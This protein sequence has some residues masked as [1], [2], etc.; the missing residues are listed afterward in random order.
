MTVNQY[1]QTAFKRW[2][3]SILALTGKAK[4]ERIDKFVS[5]MHTW[6]EHDKRFNTTPYAICQRYRHKRENSQMVLV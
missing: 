1:R 4:K 3:F 5:W 6:S 2:A